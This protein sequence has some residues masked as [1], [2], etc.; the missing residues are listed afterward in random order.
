[1]LESRVLV[2]DDDVNQAESLRRVLALEGFQATSVSTPREALDEVAMRRP[3][4]IVSDLRMGDMT[5]LDLYRE[6]KKKHPDMLFILITGFGTME[7]AVAAMRAGVHDFL[8]KPIDT[9][10]LVIKLKK[11]LDYRELAHENVI[12]KERIARLGGV[13][14]IGVSEPMKDVLAQVDQV[15]DS[16]ATVL[17]QG[18]SGTG[19]EMIA[20]AIHLKSRRTEGPYVKVNCA[21]IPENLL[22]SELFGH[23]EGSVTGA[24]A[25]RIGKFEAA[26]GGSI[27]LDEVGE[28]PLHLQPKLLRVLQEREIERVGG[29]EAIAVDVRV[30][31]ATNRDLKKMVEAGEFRNDLYY[32]LE[33]I[34]IRLPPLRDRMD[35][36]LPLAR[37]FLARYSER[38]GRDIKDISESGMARLMSS[39]WPGNVREL[40]NSIE[41]AVVLARGE[42]LEAEDFAFVAGD[43]EGGVEGIVA[44]LL[45]TDLSL[46]ELE[47]RIILMALERCEDNVSQ[48]ARKLGMTRR[49]LQYRLEKIRSGQAEG[50]DEEEE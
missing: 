37:H 30:I 26:D 2:V 32:R 41:R 6:V 17:V 20:R 8:T 18:E 1:M 42:V 11:A 9:D 47:R 39:S 27:F 10:E 29:N 31:A 36:V 43:A 33:V 5:G 21:A 19:K 14:I 40:E 48:T 50:G 12:L 4:A 46:D 16:A 34:P 7:T 15:A 35:D 25:R 38:N 24:V 23:E 44:Q 28:I 22:E 3:D 49:S 13:S 45:G